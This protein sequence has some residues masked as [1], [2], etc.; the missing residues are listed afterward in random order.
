MQQAGGIMF[1]NLDDDAFGGLSLAKAINQTV[2]LPDNV[3]PIL[4]IKE[5]IP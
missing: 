5:I 1:W 4:S 3:L 2:I